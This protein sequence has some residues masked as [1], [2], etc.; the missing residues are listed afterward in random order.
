MSEIIKLGRHRLLCGDCRDKDNLKLLFGDDKATVIMA[1]PPYGMGKE[2]DGVKNDN[3]YREKLDE[4]QMQWYKA[5]RPHV[6]DN[7]SVYIWGNAE[8]LWRLWYK[9][10]LND[11]ERVTLRNEIVWS[12]GDA[13]AG[14]ISHQ[15]HKKIRF[16]PQSTE[17]C[18]FF[19]LGEQVFNKN[20][21]NYWEGWEPIRKYL[22]NEYKKSGYTRK[23]LNKVLGSSEKSCGGIL[24]HYIDEAQFSFPPAKQYKKLQTYC[25]QNNIDAFKKEYDELKKEY[26][27]RAYF[28]NTHENMTDVWQYQRVKGKE[29]WGHPTPKPVDMISRIIKSSCSENKIV[30]DPFLGSG[31]TII[32]AE[33]NNRICYGAEI[34]EKWCNVIIE[35]Y[36]DM[37][38]DKQHEFKLKE[39]HDKHTNTN[40]R[41]S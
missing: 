8:G 37:I 4:F 32:S 39:K 41:N 33:K 17:R 23:E 30:F 13:G 16:Y 15:G 38:N 18:L 22:Y 34:S 27:T 10:G 7:G 36:K 26:A 25:Q 14:G 11:V 19:M 21:D 5:A 40:Q 29:R 2:K 24:S 28:N 9:G 20:A 12:K 35:R 1:D 3:L 6:V 31:T